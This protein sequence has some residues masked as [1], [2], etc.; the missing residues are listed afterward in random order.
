MKKLI[1]ESKKVVNK[2]LLTYS[3]NAVDSVE[4]RWK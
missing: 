1:N 3:F 4:N 2:K